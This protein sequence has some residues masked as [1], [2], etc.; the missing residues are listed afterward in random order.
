MRFDGGSLDDADI[1]AIAGLTLVRRVMLN[2]TK[3]SR[4]GRDRLVALRPDMFVQWPRDTMMSPV[5]IGR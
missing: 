2:Q 1:P 4:A 3:V 5:S